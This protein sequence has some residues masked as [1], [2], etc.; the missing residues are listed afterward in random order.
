MIFLDGFSLLC[1]AP[2]FYE[3]NL[4]DGKSMDCYPCPLRQFE[5]HVFGSETNNGNL[6]WVFEIPLVLFHPACI[7][8]DTATEGLFGTTPD[9]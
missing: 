3:V 1:P 2:V 6:F 7:V 9:L 5:M 4:I 8:F